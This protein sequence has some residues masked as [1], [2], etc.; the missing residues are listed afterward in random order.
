MPLFGVTFSFVFRGSE[1]NQ[2]KNQSISSKKSISKKSISKKNRHKP[3]VC[4]PLNATNKKSNQQ[5]EK[6]SIRSSSV[7]ARL[8][9]PAR[10]RS[11]PPPVCHRCD[12]RALILSVEAAAVV[13]VLSCC[14][15]TG[16]LFAF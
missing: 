8:F 6:T 13:F 3:S 12:F 1:I 4:H 5:S 7:A 9:L 14:S 2:S 10:D 11:R 15:L 16:L